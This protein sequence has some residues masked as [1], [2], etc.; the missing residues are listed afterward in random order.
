[1][2][3]LQILMPPF[4]ILRH[5]DFLQFSQYDLPDCGI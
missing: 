5:Y 1:M 3:L 4:A 2:S